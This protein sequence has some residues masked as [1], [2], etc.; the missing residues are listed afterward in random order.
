MVD[1]DC[2]RDGA[3]AMTELAAESDAWLDRFYA[4]SYRD[5]GRWYVEFWLAATG[6]G[7]VFLAWPA[8]HI[9]QMP[10]LGH[11]L[12]DLSE[13]LVFELAGIVVTVLAFPVLIRTSFRPLILFV[14]GDDVDPVRVWT[15]VVRLV[16]AAG[17]KMT[18]LYSLIGNTAGVIYAGHRRHF[19][20]GFGLAAWLS[21]TLITITALAFFILVWEVALRPILR[22]LEPLLPPDFEPG[23]RWMTLPRRTVLATV[24]VM[25]YTG[26]AT[27]GLVVGFGSR[28]VRLLVAPVATLAAA[29]TFGGLVTILVLHSIT[30]RLSVLNKAMESIRNGD[31]STRV[32]VRDGDEFDNVGRALNQMVSRLEKH[33][34]DLQASRARLAVASDDARRRMELDLRLRV[35]AKV[36]ELDV[37][38]ASL[39]E[40]LA[41]EPSLLAVCEDV[42]TELATASSDIRG[43][44]RGIYPALL[45]S[46]GLGAALADLT[47]RAAIPARVESTVNQ[48]FR[49]DVESAVYFCCSEALQNVTKHA[50]PEA[51]ARVEISF[52][53]GL[54]EFSVSDDGRGFDDTRV[55]RGLPNMRDR[56]RA[57]GGD[58][59]V[60]SVVGDGTVVRGWI[61]PHVRTLSRA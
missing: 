40:N 38:L 6:L 32:A 13:F 61:A 39:A 46:G 59:V 36:N 35:E 43:L 20:L 18:L 42:R 47:A 52:V 53:D 8:Q 11:G 4:K 1:L 45:E 21:E 55:G 24:S 12:F 58:V 54:L 51:A 44:G 41:D 29:G 19:G 56:L 49:R 5:R 30:M 28:E 34:S 27:S 60:E 50:G 48:R 17:V 22:D 31:F 33:R 16:P 15:S 57:L 10:L 26:S 37:A 3:A 2:G 23:K 9:T 7:I 25:T 14:R